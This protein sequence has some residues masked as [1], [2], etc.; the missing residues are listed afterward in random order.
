MAACPKE[1]LAEREWIRRLARALVGHDEL[2]EDLTQETLLVA[3]RAPPDP[4][5]P[6]RPWLGGVLRNLIA[7]NCRSEVR[8]RRRERT[9]L[10]D[11]NE[12]PPPEGMLD[13]A[14]SEALLRELLFSLAEP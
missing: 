4:N 3:L 13:H 9:V 6:A 11:F 8:R 14:R 5:R 7:R 12:P 2:A 1:L 10:D